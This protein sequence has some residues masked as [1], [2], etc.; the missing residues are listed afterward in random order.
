MFL[1][2]SLRGPLLMVVATGSYIVND[3]LMKL[4]TVGLPPYQVLAMRGVAAT[5]WGLGLLA[6][7]GQ[8]GRV[9]DAF[10]QT[11]LA[12]N[13]CELCAILCYIV[14]L[15]NMPLADVIT[16]GQ[17]TPLVILLGSAFLFGERLTMTMIALIGIGFVGAV[18]VAQPG[19]TGIS[20]YALLALGNALF[21]AARDL[22]GRRVPAALPGILVAFGA[23]V[24]VLVGA[25]AAH[26]AFEATV[27]P[28]TRHVMLLAGAGLFLFGGHY[29]L[30]MAYRSGPTGLVAP[31]FYFF[32][33]WALLSGAVVF[34][35]FPNVVALSGI[36]LVVA[37]GLA[38][39]MLDRRKS[40]PNEVH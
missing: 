17:I 34:G 11:V 8:L 18:L 3:T 33:F 19:A 24:V 36:V 30:F 27:M 32:S 23:C 7:L 10:E 39:V 13:L 37:S 38:I 35:D 25:A 16:L 29:C 31:F 20:F 9:A 12:R 1:P 28:S 5:L 6:A 4:A 40:D 22:A 2:A 14:A 26:L 21:S 15:A